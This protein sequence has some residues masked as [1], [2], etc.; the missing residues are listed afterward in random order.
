MAIPHAR[1][2]FIRR[3]YPYVVTPQSKL[4]YP[5]TFEPGE[6]FAYGVGID[7]AGRAVERVNGN[8]RLGEYM[9]KHIWGPLGMTKTTFRLDEHE[10]VRKSL[11]KMSFKLPDG[12][13]MPSPHPGWPQKPVDDI[14]GAGSY[15]CASDYI[16]VLIS[17]LRNDGKLLRAE[18]VDTMF[19]PHL[20][21]RSH[22]RRVLSF[23][24]IYAGFSGGLP[25]GK[26]L[27]WGLGGAL[28]L[29]EAA[30][31]RSKGTLNW[32]GLPNLNWVS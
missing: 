7:W 1:I 27:D 17:I 26:E 3:A 13:L 5:L 28:A 9:K 16:K 11:A 6:G 14:G 30:G 2:V 18:T 23:P 22:L 19:Q 10:E 25:A 32:S 29:E 20:E 21:D 12:K 4:V 8:I 24:E 15:S 31:Q